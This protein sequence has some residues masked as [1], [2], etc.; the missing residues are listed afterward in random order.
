MV[1]C[2]ETGRPEYSC[3]DQAACPYC[4]PESE[5]WPRISAADR[6]WTIKYAGTCDPAELR[7]IGVPTNVIERA[8]LLKRHA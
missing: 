8:E 7:K 2:L 6:A 4:G 1:D 3:R 5:D